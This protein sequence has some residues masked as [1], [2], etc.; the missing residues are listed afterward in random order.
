MRTPS[1]QYRFVFCALLLTVNLWGNYPLLAAEPTAVKIV[2]PEIVTLERKTTRPASVHAYHNVDVYARVSGY[3][4]QVNVDIGDVV[5]ADQPLAS[6][7]V[8]EMIA[9][10]KQQLAE[11]VQL[12]SEIERYEALAALAKTQITVAEADVK[13][14]DAQIAADQIEYDRIRK[15]TESKSI[16]ERLRDE[17]LSRLETSK[18]SRLAVV[19]KVDVAKAA[20]KAANAD[21]STAKTL[22]DVARK[23]HDASKIMIAY[24][25]LLAPFDGVVSQRNLDPGELVNSG[26]QKKPLFTIIHSQKVRIRAAIPERDVTWVDVGDK[27][28]FKYGGLRDG[29]ISGHVTRLAGA[30]DPKTRTMLVEMEIDNKEGDLLP[31]MFGLLTITLDH[32]PDRIVVPASTLHQGGPGQDPVVYVVESDD[33]VSHVPVSVGLDDGKRIEIIKGLSGKERIVTGMLGRLSPGQKVRVI[34]PK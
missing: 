19:A 8:P 31:G 4:K 34:S 32:R 12:K 27:A 14:S 18:A 3:A 7:N 29:K 15:L 33:T 17:I 5:K 1:F 24:A 9:G 10:E 2:K 25:T 22:V 21:T 28:E 16:S 23:K 26:L 6:I 13:K 11:I 20:L 30:L